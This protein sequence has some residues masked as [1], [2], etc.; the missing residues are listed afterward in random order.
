MFFILRDEFPGEA[1][2]KKILHDLLF[3]RE[4]VPFPSTV[5]KKWEVLRKSSIRREFFQWVQASGPTALM[6]ANV[7]R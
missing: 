3:L 4:D 2:F 5:S 1:S 6:S 7:K